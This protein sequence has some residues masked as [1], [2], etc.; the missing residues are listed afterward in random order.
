MA[1]EAVK[2]RTPVGIVSFPHVFKPQKNDQDKDVWSMV[3]LI[4]KSTDITELKNAINKVAKAKWGLKTKD[5]KLNYPLKDGDTLR[6]EDGELKKDK[7]PEYAGHYVLT[8]N[9]YNPPVIYDPKKKKIEGDENPPSGFYAGCFAH[10]VISIKPYDF[11]KKGVKCWLQGA[12][13]TK[14]GERLGGG[15][16]DDDFD[17]IESDDPEDIDTDEETGDV[18][19]SLFG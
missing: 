18:E 13:K 15:I 8:M 12:Q 7:Y 3:L 11:K 9:S 5:M 10:A 19:D 4:P 16:S 14:N 1:D 2:L 17:V 6:G